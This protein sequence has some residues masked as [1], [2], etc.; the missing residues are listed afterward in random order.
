MIVFPWLAFSLGIEQFG[1][2]N[3]I[4]AILAYLSLLVDYGI[5]LTATRD[6]AM[7]LNNVQKNSEVFWVSLWVKTLLCL[8]SFFIL[9]F[10]GLILDKISDHFSMY[11]L[12]FIMPISSLLSTTYFF[13][14]L[15]KLE[16]PSFAN[17]IVRLLSLPFLFLFVRSPSDLANAILIAALPGFVVAIFCMF[18][19][20]RYKLVKKVS[21]TRQDIRNGFASGL[22]PFLTS[23]LSTI[24]TGSYLIII[25]LVLNNSAVAVFAVADK[26]MKTLNAMI[27]PISMAVY[28][29]ISKF[30]VS[31]LNGLKKLL[32]FV[33]FINITLGLVIALLIY[34]GGFDIIINLLF[35]DK[36]SGSLDLIRIVAVG[37]LFFG[38]LQI[39]YMLLL[40]MKKEVYM[41]KIYG[42]VLIVHLPLLLII[43]KEYKLVGSATLMIATDFLIMVAALIM[44]IRVLKAHLARN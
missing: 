8:I 14:G 24:Y 34:S 31:S 27:T 5:N 26:I 22:Y 6:V 41:T 15:G 18:L 12:A 20:R 10:L 30:V 29:D 32:K 9:L 37:P 16:I 35:S 43:S 42:L 13:Q 3:F 39:S 40:S 1:L 7:N 19:I 38:I 25:G 17:L 36:Y 23:G 11:L 2:Y 44:S 21:I 33:V 4:F 28:H